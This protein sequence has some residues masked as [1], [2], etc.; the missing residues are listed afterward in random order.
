MS[1]N[2]TLRHL[3]AGRLPYL[4]LA[5]ETCLKRRRAAAL[6]LYA[7]SGPAYF[8]CAV[9]SLAAAAFLLAYAYRTTSGAVPGSAP[10][11]QSV[12]LTSESR[13]PR[14]YPRRYVL[15]V[16]KA[17]DTYYG[18]GQHYYDNLTDLFDRRYGKDKQAWQVI[19]DENPRPDQ[20]PFAPTDIPVAIELRIPLP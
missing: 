15:H 14:G 12:P 19:Q 4:R 16:V 1:L 7:A 6:Y 8:L 9:A 2:L 3:H 18:L 11:Q 17:G 5:E 10:S 20:P 13:A